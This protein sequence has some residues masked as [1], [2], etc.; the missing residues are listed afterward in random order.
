MDGSQLCV[1]GGPTE[2]SVVFWVSSAGLVDDT[3]LGGSH[4]LVGAGTQK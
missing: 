1:C 3:V 2:G 4:L